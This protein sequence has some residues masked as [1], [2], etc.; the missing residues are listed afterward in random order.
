MF[1]QR[2]RPLDVDARPHFLVRFVTRMIAYMRLAGFDPVVDQSV[3]NPGVPS[4]DDIE[5]FIVVPVEGPRVSLLDSRGEQLYR[6]NGTDGRFFCETSTTWLDGPR[7]I[8]NA[9]PGD[10]HHHRRPVSVEWRWAIFVEL[11]M[12]YHCASRRRGWSLP[13]TQPGGIFHSRQARGAHQENLLQVLISMCR[14]IY[15]G[16][17]DALV[18]TWAKSVEK[19]SGTTI[20]ARALRCQTNGQVLSGFPSPRNWRP[21]QGGISLTKFFRAQRRLEGG[22]ILEGFIGMAAVRRAHGLM[23]VPIAP[24]PVFEPVAP[25]PVESDEGSDDDDG[26]DRPMEV[27][28]EDRIEPD[29]LRVP[30]PDVLVP[31]VQ[32]QEGRVEPNAP[33]VPP[34]EPLVPAVLPDRR[35]HAASD[36]SFML[37]RHPVN[38]RLPAIFPDA[39]IS[40][41]APVV[42]VRPPPDPIQHLRLVA[43]QVREAVSGVLASMAPTA[44]P[45]PVF[46]GDHPGWELPS[47]YG[48]DE[49]RR[50]EVVSPSAFF[51]DVRR[52]KKIY[53]EDEDFY[54][55][56][57]DGHQY[58]YVEYLEVDDP[59]NDGLLAWYENGGG[60]VVRRDPGPVTPD[61]PLPPRS[62]TLGARMVGQEVMDRRRYPRVLR[63]DRPVQEDPEALQPLRQ[64]AYY[65][66]PSSDVE[67]LR[68]I[69]SIH[70]RVH[71]DDGFFPGQVDLVF[72]FFR[73]GERS[74][75]GLFAAWLGEEL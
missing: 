35:H 25:G 68:S 42:R 57:V 72:Q 54:Q 47:A 10:V 16:A 61:E 56:I 65:M 26:A 60:P 14:R 28:Q 46:D 52:I 27:D 18:Y 37:H 22:P 66:A 4:D 59:D 62:A 53:Y 12:R 30:P 36:L 13:E 63:P 23:R 15:P 2:Q 70:E 64:W 38:I 1:R 49:P 3:F 41:A 73:P 21:G 11:R 5:Q 19:N 9:Q 31:A 20:R 43:D 8:C 50:L 39:L 67:Y 44:P 40:H 17:P 34:T 29:A 24:V 33:R 7:P 75:S 32:D 58:F 74:N 45:R 48:P 51:R 55:P 6:W 71:P 69:C